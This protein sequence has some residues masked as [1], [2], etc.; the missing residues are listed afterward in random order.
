MREEVFVPGKVALTV[1]VL[2][3]EP[4]DIIWIIE[5]FKLAMNL[6]DILLIFV[7][8]TT[9]MVPQREHW[10]KWHLPGQPRILTVQISWCRSRNEEDVDD[11]TL[12]H[13]MRSLATSMVVVDINKSFCGIE[14]KDSSRSCFLTLTDKQWNGTIQS[15][16]NVQVVFKDV[17]IVQPVGVLVFCT[18]SY[19]TFQR[20]GRRMFWKPKNIL[21][22][23][24]CKIRPDRHW[25]VRFRIVMTLEFFFP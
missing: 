11:T 20:R 1:C 6:V 3:I 25:T 21:G 5:F 13:P 12:A 14:P 17:E 4:Q 8:P 7:I 2:N 22:S 10:W 9:L 23:W 19:R 16:W 24:E 15:H 18:F